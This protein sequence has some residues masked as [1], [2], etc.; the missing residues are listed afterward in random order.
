[1][2][3]SRRFG[4]LENE[5]DID[6][7]IKNIDDVQLYDGI[8]GHVPELDAFLRNNPLRAYLPFCKPSPTTMT[9]IAVEELENR[10]RP[11]GGYDSSGID[12]LAELLRAHDANPEK[13]G[14]DDVFSIAHG[15]V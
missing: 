13:F 9:K 10:R 5:V 12:L 14:V 15:A 7:S 3:F 11:D 6:G 1:M 4:F 8:I 2:A